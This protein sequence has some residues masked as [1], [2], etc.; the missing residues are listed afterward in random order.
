[1]TNNDALSAK[2]VT[3]TNDSNT[4]NALDCISRQAAIDA[5]EGEIE[6]TGKANAKAVL[7]YTQMV[8]DRIK[9]LPSVQPEP[10][11][12]PCEKALPKENGFYEV[13]VG[14]PYKP[15]RIYEY[16]PCDWYENKNRWKAEDGCYVFNWFVEAW[17]ECPKPYERSDNG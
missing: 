6:V 12:T 16:K 1:M 13:T 4:L 15:V 10:K 9:A 17:R 5:F 3:Q 2:Q 8:I 14:S 7:K 11:W